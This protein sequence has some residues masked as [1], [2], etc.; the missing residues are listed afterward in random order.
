M[1]HLLHTRRVQDSNALA[2]MFF[3]NTQIHAGA[4]AVCPSLSVKT[5][6]CLIQPH[7]VR[8]VSNAQLPQ[9]ELLLQGQAI[10]F[11][12]RGTQSQPSKD[13]ESP[14]SPS[15]SSELTVMK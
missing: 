3:P 1:I 9:R 15:S 4:L 7:Q 13:T 10:L 14:S 12:S 5:E 11:C 2:E 6:Q 8:R